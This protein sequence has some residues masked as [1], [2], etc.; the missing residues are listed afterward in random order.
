[1]LNYLDELFTPS[2]L[3]VQDAKGSVGMYPVGVD[4]PDALDANEIAHI[5]SSDSFYLST[6]SESGWPYTQHKGG[7]PGFVKVLGPTTI[8]WVERS[9][10]R[11]YLGSGNIPPTTRSQQSSSTIRAAPASSCAGMRPTTSIRHQSC[12]KHSTQVE[13]A[14]TAQ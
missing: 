2:V 13:P 11:Q 10:N 12:S 7:E 5:T 8:G 4:G 3:A 1:M 6:V 9:G 14:S